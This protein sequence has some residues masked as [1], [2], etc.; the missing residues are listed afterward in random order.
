MG[1]CLVRAGVGHRAAGDS[2]DGEGVWSEDVRS[3]SV[4]TRHAHLLLETLGEN[5]SDIT[6]G[7]GL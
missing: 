7:R 2:G 5:W 3:E 4:K 1:G 6:C